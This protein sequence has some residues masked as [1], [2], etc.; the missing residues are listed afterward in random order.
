[1]VATYERESYTSYIGL[2]LGRASRWVGLR[3]GLTSVRADFGTI[4]TSGR[5]GLRELC[6]GWGS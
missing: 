3:D 5:A 4:W 6:T 1:M 2:G